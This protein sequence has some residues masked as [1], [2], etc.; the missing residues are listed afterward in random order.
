MTPRF[1]RR[2]ETET[3]ADLGSPTAELVLAS[4]EH[5]PRAARQAVRDLCEGRDSDCVA[6]AEI[7]VSELVTNAVRHGEGQDIVLSLWKSWRTI[8]VD[9]FDGGSGL[10]RQSRA[11]SGTGGR[12]LG[13]VDALARS[14]GSSAEGAPSSVWFRAAMPSVTAFPHSAGLTSRAL[15]RPEF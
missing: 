15:T 10:T 5:A 11:C 8:D 6:D 3:A 7:V 2:E 9:V 4:N 13:I 14:W 12:G 1:V